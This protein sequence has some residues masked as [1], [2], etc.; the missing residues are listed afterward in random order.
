MSEEAFFNSESISDLPDHL[1]TYQY[2]VGGHGSLAKWADYKMLRHPQ[3]PIV[4]K[5]L[6]PDKRGLQEANF[7]FKVFA[8]NTPPEIAKLRPIVPMFYGLFRDS[9]DVLYIGL[10]D[11]LANLA[12]PSVCDLKMGRVACPPDASEAKIKAE[13]AKYAHRDTVGF[14]FTGTKV[15]DQ[16]SSRYLTVPRHYG[17]SLN[18]EAVYVNALLPFL[19]GDL[20]LAHSFLPLVEAVRSIFM[21]EPRPPI[22]LYRSSLLLA[23]DQYRS[24]VVVRLVDFAHCRPTSKADDPSGIIHGLD[25]LIDFLSRPE[26]PPDLSYTSPFTFSSK[27][28]AKETIG[29]LPFDTGYLDVRNTLRKRATANDTTYISSYTDPVGSFALSILCDSRKLRLSENLGDYNIT[30]S[31]SHSSNENISLIFTSDYPVSVELADPF[32]LNL[33]ASLNRSTQNVTFPLVVSQIGDAYLVARAVVAEKS[34]LA[35]GVRILVL[36]ES[37]VVDLIFRIGLI[38]LLILA[39]FFMG[40]EVNI[41]VIKSYARKPVGPILGFCCQFIIMPAVAIALAKLTPINPAF[42][43]GLFISGCCPGGGASNVWTRLLGG[44]LDLSLTMTLFSSLAALGMLPLLLFAFARFFTAIDVSAVPYGP[45][46]A[47]LLYLF[48]PV[49]SGLLIRH[50]RPTWADRLRR[51]VQPM[52]CI[53]LTYVIGFGTFA[54]FS[55]FRLMG[56]YPLIIVVGAALPIIGYVAGFL[57]ALL[58]RRSWPVIVAISIETGVQNVG[59]GILILISAIPQPQGDLGAVMPIIIAITTPLGLLI[60]LIVRLIV[61][62][63]KRRQKQDEEEELEDGS[64]DSHCSL[65]TGVEGQTRSASGFRGLDEEK[66]K[67]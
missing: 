33:S 60:A 37:G 53:F 49:V 55:I 27:V 17:R 12:N 38:I 2:Q 40:C 5:R 25:T 9:N 10:E 51:G 1:L 39:T 45:I 57:L 16:K 48:V 13:N 8:T 3:E 23:Y 18:L 21:E 56:R 22:G 58:C 66:G 4:Y 65:D 19:Q 15:Y 41:N 52:S 29:G 43:F 31:L 64:W 54:N 62:R 26:L 67:F 20:R 46:V 59:V 44:D 42:G 30:C 28:F 14:L 47:N 24:K 63:L 34:Y 61:R 32:I 11:V 6:P 50:F 35:L 36:R 7:Y